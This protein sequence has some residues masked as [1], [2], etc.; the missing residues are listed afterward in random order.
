MLLGLVGLGIIA[1]AMG[2]H[3]QD[4][5][6]GGKESP[7][8]EQAKEKQG[9]QKLYFGM[10][11]CAGCHTEKP[12]GE[13][14]PLICRCNEIPTWEE[15]KHKK[16]YAVLSEPRAQQIGK[17][18]GKDVT[19]A[20][21]GC[22]TCHGID[23]TNKK[24]SG[25]LKLKDEGVTCT[26]CHGS[27]RDWVLKHGVNIPEERKAWRELSREQK[28]REFGM[29][30]LWNP[31]KRAQWCATCHIGTSQD[32][33]GDRKIVTHEMYAAGH[34]PL[35]GFEPAIFS[36]EMPRHWHY[37][38]EK[39]KDKDVR[40]LLLQ[41]KISN[42]SYERSKL[43]LVGGIVGLMEYMKLLVAQAEKPSQGT[44]DFASYDCYACHHDLRVPSWRQNRGY[45]GRPGRPQMRPWPLALARVAVRG[46][47][48]DADEANVLSADLAKNLRAVHEAFDVQP[49]GRLEE[50]RIS[51]QKVVKY[52]QSMVEYFAT[53]KLDSVRS[54]GLLRDLCA[55]VEQEL[56]DYDSARQIAWAFGEIYGEL[57]P[58]PAND[59]K[60]REVLD[61]LRSE[62]RLQLPSGKERSITGELPSALEQLSNYDPDRTD[63]PGFKQRMKQ[64]ANLL[65]PA[66]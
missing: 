13:N 4:K 25:N 38:A 17:I 3:G 15:D 14:K 52:C 51:G 18:L 27:Y 57:N 22:V 26:V 43:V 44:L 42:D 9:P 29:K 37:Y 47:A 6:T 56:P 65:P 33:N 61:K 11:T 21:A 53:F 32:E 34:P 35:P 55:S 66:R 54:E 40:E 8:T 62:L 50:I 64:L 5:S 60:I 7:K 23:Q 20:E 2:L 58:K 45:A 59:S 10:E 31:E 39:A 16:A 30:D 63:P 19:Q 46:V 24:L 41:L 12:K 1:G 48:K 49:F 28:E 36:D